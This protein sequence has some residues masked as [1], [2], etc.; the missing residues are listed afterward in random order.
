MMK[1][2]LKDFSPFGSLVLKN[3]GESCNICDCERFNKKTVF[4][5]FKAFY[6]QLMWY[7]TRFYQ[8]YKC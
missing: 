3:L 4:F 1:M 2:T 5:L 8:L 6:L 7:L